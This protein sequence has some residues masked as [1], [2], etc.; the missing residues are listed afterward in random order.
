M[1]DVTDI[2]T[3]VRHLIEDFS[4]TMVPGDV[5]TY[6]TSN[7]FTLTEANVNSVTSVLINGS[8]IGDSE[9][10]FDSTNNKVTITASLSSG[11]TVE[12][13]YT[14]YPNYSDT[15]IENYIKGAVIHLSVNNYYTYEVDTDGE[16][17]PEIS[18]KEKNLL[19]FVTATLIEPG[20]QSYRLPD[21]T[22]SNPKSLPTRDLI[23]KSISIFKHN[24]H[25]SFDLT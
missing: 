13:Q 22:I 23:S 14:Y 19:S 5:F 2:T 25:G 12:I 3:L 9:Y 17:Y 16:I 10:A 15:E 7:V 8:E 24:T 20:N 11:D 4:R 1:S 21:M 6:T 18:E